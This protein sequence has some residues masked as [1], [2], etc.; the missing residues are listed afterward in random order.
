LYYSLIDGQPRATLSDTRLGVFAQDAWQI[1]A[2][3]LVDYGVRYDLSTFR[4]PSRARVETSVPN[5]GAGRDK[6]NWAPRFG[7]TWTPRGDGRLLVRGGAGVFYDKLVLAF[8][9]VAA[10][11]SGTRIGF[12][13][14]MGTT[15]E[16]D[17]AFVDTYGGDLLRQVLP[18]P[19]DLVLRFSTGTRLDTPYANV[20]NVGLEGSVGRSGAWSA[21]LV[22]SLGYRLPLMR[23]LNPV[24]DTFDDATDPYPRDDG[25]PVH[26][27]AG[28]GSIASVVTEGRSWYTGVDL[29]WKW[30]GEGS[31]HSVS[32]TWSRSEDLGPD[33]LKGGIYLPPRPAVGDAGPY[34]ESFAFE[35]GRSDNDRRHR[36][37]VAGEAPLPWMGLRLSGVGQ[38][39]SG[40]P[41]N[42][43]TGRDENVDGIT[44]DR[45]V[46]VG[47]NTGENTPLGPVNALRERINQLLR[48]SG[49]E[50]LAAVTSLRE[51]AYIQV[52]LR[53]S[54][55]F[56][57]GGARRGGEA[58]VQIFNVANRFNAG[59]IDGRATTRTFGRPI[60]QVGPART[61][62]LG[63]KLA[64]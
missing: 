2:R 47:R 49:A 40:A 62:E 15:V 58:Y 26:R 4:L 59:P 11:T 24:V 36:F 9:A 37:V 43:T 20:F 53:L 21:N 46:G 64:L 25:L 41:F 22:R 3:V 60:G 52:D 19:G 1:N 56:A 13:P 14:P 57:Y 50:E 18:F 44:T 16:L 61:V 8:P 12:F 5:G 30:Q 42:V 35:R 33:P 54:R 32:Y 23:D 45:P 39:M 27:T 29:T 51:P 55:P 28:V 31:W 48:L 6:D 63:L 34:Y 10:I 38:Y 7:F 17:E